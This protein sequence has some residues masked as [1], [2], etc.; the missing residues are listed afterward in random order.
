MCCY[1]KICSTFWVKH[2]KH[3]CA[4][5]PCTYRLPLIVLYLKSLLCSQ[6]YVSS[7][8]I[9]LLTIYNVFM[10]ARLRLSQIPLAYSRTVVIRFS[11]NP[12]YIQSEYTFLTTRPFYAV[13]NM[14]SYLNSKNKT[15]FKLMEEVKQCIKKAVSN[16]TSQNLLN[17]DKKLRS[18]NIKLNTDKH[19]SRRKFS[20]N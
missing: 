1:R 18:M 10:C 12:S 17:K 7:V 19:K 8:S 13:A 6:V 20:N 5:T 4:Q 15:N 9:N 14:N 11:I 16:L 3:F 2:V